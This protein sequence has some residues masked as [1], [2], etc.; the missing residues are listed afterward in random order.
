MKNLIFFMII[1]LVVIY[2]S[3]EA[4]PRNISLN[5]EI[6]EGNTT[7]LDFGSL[8]VMSERGEP[9]T[10]FSTRLVKISIT[11]TTDFQYKVT[12]RLGGP[13]L[14]ERDFELSSEIMTSFAFGAKTG[15][16]L[17]QNPTPLSFAEQVIFVSD[18]RGEDDSFQLQYN[19]APF[20]K[21]N[22]GRYRSNI[23]YTVTTME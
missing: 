23:I 22:A 1:F 13:V 5:I 7:D 2:K 8:K 20:G 12:Q 10:N 21:T 19:L 18:V 4:Y 17:I 11:N 16:L 14:N 6:Q 9:L 15:T 3:K